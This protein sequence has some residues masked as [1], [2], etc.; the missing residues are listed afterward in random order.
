[1]HEQ[2]LM[3]DLMR[4]ILALAEKEGATRV[5]RVC[6][7]LGALSHMSPEHFKEHFD[8]AAQGTLAE[9]ALLDTQQ[10]EDINAPEAQSIVLRSIDVT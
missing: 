7:A 10:L 6:V 9:N 4:K 2:S 8:I 5:T 3:N 1:M